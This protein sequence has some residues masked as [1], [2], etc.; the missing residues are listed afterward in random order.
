MN[1]AE[2]D[3]TQVGGP[4]VPG[5]TPRRGCSAL[6]VALLVLVVGA[7]FGGGAAYLLLSDDERRAVDAGRSTR[8]SDAESTSTSRALTTSATSVPVTTTVGS[9]GGSGSGSG[10]AKNT[11]TT[12]K[13]PKPTIDTFYAAQNPWEC[14]T[15]HSSNVNVL[16]VWSTSNATQTTVDGGGGIYGP[17]DS[18]FQNYQCNTFTQL[19]KLTATGPGG[20]TQLQIS[21]GMVDTNPLK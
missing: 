7:L 3:E 12:T 4:S 17:D 5:S 10:G 1:G 11:T 8:T 16:F 15:A 21:F 6:L 18:S 14:N 20:E 19:K 9:G 13:P 2:P